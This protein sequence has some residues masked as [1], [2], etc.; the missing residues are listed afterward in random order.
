MA[1]SLSVTF[2]GDEAGD[3]SFAFS[4]GASRYFVVVLI[5]TSQPDTLRS[6]LSEFR[7]QHSLPAHH[8]FSFHRLAGLRLLTGLFQ[9]LTRL[10][11]SIWT[12]VVDKQALPDSFRVMRRL[13]FYVY[14][15]TELIRLIPE[16]QR[17]NASLILDEFDRS[18]K[19]INS[20]RRG[21]RTRAIPGRFK[22]IT[23]RRS[24][25][26]PLIQIAD[27]VAGATL[28]KFSK[29]EGEMQAMLASKYKL[30]YEYRG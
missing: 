14:F 11:I 15:V 16:G 1:S 27:L 10:D 30:L 21:L 13:D 28:R 25:S 20:L 22:Q 24:A 8:E 17:S 4:Q 23:T 9:F 3:V 5:E 19:I 18:G 6:A 12:L 7:Q 26:E 2:A 29:N